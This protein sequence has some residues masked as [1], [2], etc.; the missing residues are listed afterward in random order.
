M[1]RVAACLAML[2]CGGEDPSAPKTADAGSSY[3]SGPWLWECFCNRHFV[4]NGQVYDY[5][6]PL[7]EFCAYTSGE[8]KGMASPSCPTTSTQWTHCPQYTGRCNR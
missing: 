4:G 3:Y 6:F 1:I 5:S 2:A 8:A 7:G